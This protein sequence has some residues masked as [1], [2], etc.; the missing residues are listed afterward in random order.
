[1]RMDSNLGTHKIYAIHCFSIYQRNNDNLTGK[2]FHRNKYT[3]IELWKKKIKQI[4]CCAETSHKE[5]Q[6]RD[7]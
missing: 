7:D 2:N 1:M 4:L 5:K 3:A 6:S